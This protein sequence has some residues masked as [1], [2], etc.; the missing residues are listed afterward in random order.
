MSRLLGQLHRCFWVVV[1]PKEDVDIQKG[2]SEIHHGDSELCRFLVAVRYSTFIKKG[3]NEREKGKDSLSALNEKRIKIDIVIPTY[4]GANHIPKLLETI[5]C[6]T[7]RNYKCFVIDDNSRD[8]TVR[9]L[10]ERFPWVTLIEQ[11]NNKGPAKNRNIGIRSGDSPYIVIFDDDTFLEDPE[12]L[13]KALYKMEKN[14]NIGQLASM[15]VSGFDKD[16]LLDCGIHKEGLLFGGLYYN[17]HRG[18]TSGKHEISR[19]VL[20]ACSA[21]TVLRRDVFEKAGGFDPK[22]FYPVEDL[23]LSTRI[24]LT[25]YDVIYEPSLI[26][27][28]FESQAMGKT[29]DRKMYMYRRNCLLAF[30]ENYPRGYVVRTLT[31]FVAGS[32]KNRVLS[33]FIPAARVGKKVQYAQKAKDCLKAFLFFAVNSLSIIRKRRKIDRFKTRP[34]GYLLDVDHIVEQEVS[35]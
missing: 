12:W 1:L 31:S 17:Q 24:H 30:I 34:R 21:G 5:S 18:N 4:N 14:P 20:G 8:D 35:S 25:G 28:H 33:L 11:S 10:R 27:Y 7:Y 29:I 22:Y 2:F 19:R 15:I 16:I 3:Q 26:T 9:I 6:Q 23:D 13:Y 32:L